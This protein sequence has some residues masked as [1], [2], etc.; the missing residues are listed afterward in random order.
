MRQWLIAMSLCLMFFTLSLSDRVFGKL[1][2]INPLMWPSP[3]E[4]QPA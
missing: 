4:Y 1:M 3:R 2:T